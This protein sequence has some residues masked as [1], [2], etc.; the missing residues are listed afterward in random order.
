MRNSFALSTSRTAIR[1]GG[2]EREACQCRQ[3]QLAPAACELVLP[4]RTG[5][6]RTRI[7]RPEPVAQ[8]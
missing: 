5:F 6:R 3:Y 2:T 7:R 8:R 4:T 1:F